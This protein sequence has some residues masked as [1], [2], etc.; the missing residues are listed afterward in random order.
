M[1]LRYIPWPPEKPEDRQIRL[2][3]HGSLPEAVHVFDRES[4]EALNAALGARRPLLVRGEPGT[5]KSQLARAAAAAMK[6]PFLSTV[7]DARTESRDLFWSFDAVSRLAQAQIQQALG[8]A[9]AAKVRDNLKEERFLTPGPLW[10]TFHWKDAKTQAQKVNATLPPE[11]KGWKPTD[12]VVLLIDEIDKADS[13]VPNGLLEALGQ[14]Q[15]ECPGGKVVTWNKDAAPPLVVITTNEERALPDPFLRRCLVLHLACPDKRG[16]LIAWLVERGKAHFP[17]E[18]LSKV[19]QQA[20]EMLATD[21][22]EIEKQ[23]L[24]PPGGAEYLDLV[25]ALVDLG[26]TEDERLELLKRLRG[27]TYRKHPAEPEW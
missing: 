11:P 17:D 10:W 15:I 22:E 21:R 20:A 8:I 19:L 25:R 12:G 2:E 4:V 13:S 27:F 14:G 1:T 5:G 23:S 18:G 6:R 26:D 9:D 24:T 7:I 3:Q 16:D